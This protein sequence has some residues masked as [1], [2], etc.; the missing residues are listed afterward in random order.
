M[1]TNIIIDDA[2]M[3]Q[4]MTASGFATKKKTVEEGLRLLIRL[5]RQQSVRKFRGKLRWHGDLEAM[6]RDR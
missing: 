5:K 1:R 2:L 6:R 3:Q 4:A